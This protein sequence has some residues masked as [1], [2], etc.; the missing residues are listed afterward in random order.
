MLFWT[1]NWHC[2]NYKG[3]K[4]QVLEI[5]SVNYKFWKLMH[6]WRID[7][8]LKRYKVYFSQTHNI[9]SYSKFSNVAVIYLSL[10]FEYKN[11]SG[12]L[13][14]FFFFCFFFFFF[15]IE[16]QP[17]ASFFL[18]IV[19]FIIKPRHQSI[20]SASEDLTSNLL[21]NHQKIFRLS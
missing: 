20:F 11:V 10:F 21:F 17:M 18:I 13:V 9:T 12:W 15:W 2:H 1:K 6:R 19:L 7:S 4:M 3:G 5:N 8:K 14:F 16:F